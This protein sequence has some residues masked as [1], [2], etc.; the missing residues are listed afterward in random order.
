M[1]KTTKMTHEDIFPFMCEST[2]EI[3]CN[4]ESELPLKKSF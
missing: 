2:T 1:K 4:Y 3:V